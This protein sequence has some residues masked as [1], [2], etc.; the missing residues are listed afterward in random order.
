M[1]LIEICN[2][3][4]EFVKMN[5][6]HINPFKRVEVHEITSDYSQCCHFILEYLLLTFLQKEHKFCKLHIFNMNIFITFALSE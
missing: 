1:V 2:S 3:C 4:L 5:T 6:K